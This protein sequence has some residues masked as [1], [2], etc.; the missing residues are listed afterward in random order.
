MK[1]EIIFCIPQL[2]GGGAEQQIKYLANIF[3]K[4]YKVKIIALKN[5][6]KEGFNPDIEIIK[7]R[8]LSLKRI[9]S[10]K[11]F[12][13]LR[14]EIKGNH[15]ISASIYFDILCGLLKIFTRFNWFIR[16]S[17]SSKARKDNFKNR[18][19]KFLGRNAKGIIANSE[20]GYKYWKLINKNSK[21]IYNGYPREILEKTKLKKKDYAVIASRLQPHKNIKLSIDLFDKLKKEGYIKRLIICG[22]GPEKKNIIKYIN[23]SSNKNH[24]EIKG[25][26]N[27]KKLQDILSYSK[28]FLSMSSYEGTP[29]S[30]IEA[31]ANYCEVFLSDSSSHKDFFPS[32]IVNFVSIKNLNYKKNN[33]KDFLKILEFIKEFNIN[34]VSYKYKTFI[35]I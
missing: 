14:K 3:A 25:F 35:N 15:V 16:E 28:C 23:K 6:N 12:L 30:V 29:N 8:K 27:H 32:N 9:S 18:L 34:K 4:E 24:I 19:R 2:Y 21:L 22:D 31:L 13:I 17:N 11:A 20:S 33:R 26:I 5:S 10:I 7:I 1:K